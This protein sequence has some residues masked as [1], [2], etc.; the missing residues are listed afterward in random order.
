MTASN[1]RIIVNA[2]NY[3]NDRKTF[4][5]AELLKYANSLLLENVV[6]ASGT[7]S[8][9]KQKEYNEAPYYLEEEN[10]I[11]Y[12]RNIETDSTELEINANIVTEL[13]IENNC[14]WFT[15]KD[16]TEISIYPN[17]EL[18]ELSQLK[19]KLYLQESFYTHYNNW[20]NEMSLLQKAISDNIGSNIILDNEVTLVLEK[21]TGNKFNFILHS[22]RYGDP[23]ELVINYKDL[24]YTGINNTKDNICLVLKTSEI[25]VDI[26]FKDTEIKKSKLFS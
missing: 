9:V 6:V 16:G 18:V 14:I 4:Y 25:R 22:S 15:K 1:V 23:V 2:L 7:E 19:T 24:R 5:A 11:L 12:L 21:F 26:M 10:D 17:K 3:T 13:G 8:G 20:Y